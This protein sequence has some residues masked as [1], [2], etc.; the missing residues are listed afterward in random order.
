MFTVSFSESN[1]HC[2]NLTPEGAGHR[3]Q[4][5]KSHVTIKISVISARRSIIFK[6]EKLC[7][8]HWM[9]GGLSHI[10]LLGPQHETKDSTAL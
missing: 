10:K 1:E 4:L 6:D 3:F 7:L 9:G 8:N 5:Q 2:A